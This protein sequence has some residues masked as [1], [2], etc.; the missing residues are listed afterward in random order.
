MTE[1]PRGWELCAVSDIADLLS[2]PAFESAHFRPDGEGVRLLR[3]DNIEPGS[4]RWL[5]VRCW[6]S[7]RLEG[8]EHL[9]LEPGDVIL[10]MDRPIIS[11]GL[12]LALTRSVDVPSLLVQRVARLRTRREVSERFLYFALQRDEFRGH[13]MHGQTGTQLPH[14]SLKHI[15]A[16]KM[17]LAPCAEQERIVAAIEEAFSKLDAGEAGLRT[18]RQLIKRTRQ[19]VLGAAVAGR[20][21]AADPSDSPAAKLLADIGVEPVEAPPGA[22]TPESWAW[23]GM[24]DVAAIGGG[25]QKQPKRA[26]NDNP[27]PFLRVANVGRGNL[28]LEDVHQVEVFDGELERYRLQAGDLLVVEGNG[29]PEQIGRSAMWHGEIDPC[30]HQN[31]LIRVRPANVLVPRFLELYWNSPSASRRVQAVASSTS[32][33]HTLSTGKLKALPVVV[34]PPPE[35]ARIVEEVERQFS[36]LDACDRAVDFGL[37]HSAALRRSVLKSAFEGKLATQDPSDEPASAL[38][39]RIKATRPATKPTRPARAT[40]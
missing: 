33:L 21:V 34:P 12:K 14:V 16:F 1:L 27:V 6:P 9:L 17:A 30:V 7:E 35:Q 39:E 32:G 4:L 3:G 18:V 19:A 24:G 23:A 29:S 25:I 10:A 11:S 20:L 5:N 38:L 37:A 15:G 8:N 28:D 36:F 26:P 31:H 22:D 2:G 40:A 13:L